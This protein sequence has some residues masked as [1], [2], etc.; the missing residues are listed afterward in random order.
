MRVLSSL[1]FA[2]G[3]AVASSASSAP[4]EWNQE[5]VTRLATELSESLGDV[6]GR[7]RA[8]D[9]P[10]V[11]GSRKSF[12]RALDDLRVLKNSVRHLTRRLQ[13]GAGY[14]ETLPIY[15]RVALMR[16]SAADEGRRSAGALP[17]DVLELV[18]QAGEQLDRLSAYYESPE[19]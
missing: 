6:Y 4:L 7:A 1:A 11:G 12:F 14:D 17:A 16:R 18:E 2:L 5:Q 19:E 8:V 9:P 10:L 3:F 13:A 15:R